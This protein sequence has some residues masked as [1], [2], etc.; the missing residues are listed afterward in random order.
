MQL[1]NGKRLPTVTCDAILGFFG[2]YRYLSNYHLIQVVVEGQ[3]YPSSEHAYMAQKNSG[4]LMQAYIA[5]LPSPADA[6]R[7]GQTLQPPK[8]W[9]ETRIEAM[10][11]V[12]AAKFSD[13]VLRRWLLATGDR[14]LEETNDWGDTFW[15]V[16]NGVGGNQ[17]GKLLMELR[18]ALRAAM[19]A[20]CAYA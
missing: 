1:I 12:L 15:G 17:L 9:Y 10:R 16:C 18:A 7:F 20:Q 5:A 8:H 19:P 13:S 14:Y 6:R 2:E 3:K 4:F 11:N